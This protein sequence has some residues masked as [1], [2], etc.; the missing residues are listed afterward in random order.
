MREALYHHDGKCQVH[1]IN[2]N[3]MASLPHSAKF[4]EN[5]K[6]WNLMLWG[7]WLAEN[8]TDFIQH[9][10]LAALVLDLYRVLEIALAIEHTAQPAGGLSSE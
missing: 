3:F 1:K 8:R 5:E 6:T 9:H 2:A 10:L 7:H 4:Y